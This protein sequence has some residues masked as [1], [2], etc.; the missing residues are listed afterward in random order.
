MISR[1]LSFSRVSA[2]NSLVNSAAGSSRF[3]RTAW[4]D[5]NGVKSADPAISD[6]AR[7]GARAG[8][9]RKLRGK[10]GHWSDL[11][12]E[13]IHDPSCWTAREYVGDCGLVVLRV[14]QRLTIDWTDLSLRAMQVSR[15][16][17]HP[18]CTKSKS[19]H[20]STRIGDPSSG[21]DWHFYGVDHLWHQRHC[22]D[23]CRNIL[24]EKHSPMPTSLVTL[25]DNFVASLILKPARLIHRSRRGNNL[26]ARPP[27]ACQQ[28]P[29][30]KTEM[31]ANDLRLELLE[32]IAHFVVER[33]AVGAQNSSIV[34]ELQLNVVGI[35]T[36]SP[37]QFA[38][39]L[40]PRLLVTEEVHI[41]WARCF[42]A[43]GF[44]LHA[45][46]FHTQQCT[47][48]RTEPS[49]FRNSDDHIR[50]CRSSHRRLNNW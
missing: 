48:Q 32:E 2:A 22:A 7:S 13:A 17:L 12:H 29:V 1:N 43:N 9:E 36:S 18:Y 41:D 50:K 39:R 5:H 35:Q 23:L 31:E 21:D 4:P 24:C 37:A 33:S 26:R 49:C 14:L 16:D 19:C 15:A 20:Y 3:R 8:S 44:Q 38:S 28:I 42:S 34:I 10:I 45:R 40:V 25:G 46:L 11:A 30:R 27:N 47:C 6:F